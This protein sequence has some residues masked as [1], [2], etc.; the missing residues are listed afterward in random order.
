LTHE[1]YFD[2]LPVIVLPTFVSKFFGAVTTVFNAE[3]DVLATFL[4]VFDTELPTELIGL[5][6]DAL[7][8]RAGCTFIKM[9]DVTTTADRTRFIP[10]TMIFTFLIC[11]QTKSNTHKETMPNTRLGREC[12]KKMRDCPGQFSW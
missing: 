5:K 8:Q 2:F 3:T 4:L 11:R 10:T 7:L 1:T 12:R 6:S 9:I